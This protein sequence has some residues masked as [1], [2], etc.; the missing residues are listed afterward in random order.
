MPATTEIVV[1]SARQ[2]FAAAL[3]ETDKLL[4]NRDWRFPPR[5]RG[6]VY[7]HSSRWDA[8][9]PADVL[10]V[11]PWL[12]DLWD[13]PTPLAT[14][15]GAIIGR[16]D[17]V[18]AADSIDVV[19]CYDKLAGQSRRT[20]TP[21]QLE[22]LPYLPPVNKSSDPSTDPWRWWAGGGVLIFKNPAILKQPIPVSGKL[23]LWR[24]SVS[25]DRLAFREVRRKKRRKRSG[26]GGRLDDPPGDD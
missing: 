7:V 3:L 5:Y 20:L 26:R 19:E 2:P 24:R 17:L 21:R 25:S 4:E 23:G 8:R 6:P 15:T 22:L 14:V 11:D 16:V 18:C 9:P 1:L 13:D 12:A 10:A